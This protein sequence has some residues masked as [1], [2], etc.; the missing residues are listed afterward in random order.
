MNTNIYHL[1]FRVSVVS[2]CV[3]TASLLGYRDL[4]AAQVHSPK[5]QTLAQQQRQ[6]R[7][8][9]DF[10]NDYMRSCKQS[11]VKQGVS[12][13]LA[14]KLCTCTINRFQARFTLDQFKALSRQAQQNGEPPEVF[15]EIGEACA[16]QLTS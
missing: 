9:Q 5:P 13:Q 10:I 11:A 16:E 6:N 15:T 4:R 14:E 12:Q 1:F 8:P 7:Y 2:V 3:L